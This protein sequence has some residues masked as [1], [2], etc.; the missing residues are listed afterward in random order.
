MNIIFI[1][2]LDSRRESH[3]IYREMWWP[4]SHLVQ[5]LVCSQREMSRAIADS[6]IAGYPLLSVARDSRSDIALETAAAPTGS[7]IDLAAA[8][9]PVVSVATRVR[10]GQ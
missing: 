2:S 10:F 8:M 3:P 9:N 5:A 6:N 1:D 4:H 7:A